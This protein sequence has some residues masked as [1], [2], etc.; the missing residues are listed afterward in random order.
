VF[1]DP[2]AIS[3]MDRVIDGEQRWRTI[4]RIGFTTIVFVGH[5][6]VDEDGEIHVRV[7]TVRRATRHEIKGYETG[8]EGYLR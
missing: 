6:W 2:D 4:G 5:T 3:G 1:D 7:I 8:D